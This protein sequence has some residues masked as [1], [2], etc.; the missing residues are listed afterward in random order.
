VFLS[1]V[2]MT[3]SKFDSLTRF[4]IV[5]VYE[6]VGAN[7][8]DR[9]SNV[10]VKGPP[11]LTRFIVHEPPPILLSMLGLMMIER[12]KEMPIEATFLREVSEIIAML[13]VPA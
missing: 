9:R 8:V 5:E 2:T 10:V 1:S 6:H 12:C 11:K 7:N 3:E 4:E 13:L